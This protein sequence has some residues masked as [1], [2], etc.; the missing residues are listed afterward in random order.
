MLALTF[1][2]SLLFLAIIWWLFGGSLR[3]LWVM[4]YAMQI[5]CY[6]NIYDVVFPPNAEEFVEKFLTILEWDIFNPIRYAEIFHR[7]FRFPLFL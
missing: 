7:Y 1:L 4:Y 5:A 2:A 6:L 3:D